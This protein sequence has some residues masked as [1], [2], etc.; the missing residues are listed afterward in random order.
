MT[1]VRKVFDWIAFWGSL[2]FF[3]VIVL[4]VLL[5]GFGLYLLCE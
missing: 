5:L 2:L 3:S 4:L 1:E